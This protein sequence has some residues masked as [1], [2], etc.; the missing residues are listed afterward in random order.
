MDIRLKTCLIIRKNNRYLV[1]SNQIT[2]GLQW[3]RDHYD[4]WRTRDVR[5]AQSMARIIGGTMMLFNPV[6]GQIRVYGR[7]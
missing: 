4:A 5:T 7:E 2:G 3:S 6:A 1:G